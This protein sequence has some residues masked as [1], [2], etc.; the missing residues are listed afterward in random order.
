MDLC[1]D[2]LDSCLNNE[3]FIHHFVKV[4]ILHS[5][6][7]SRPINNK[8]F[9]CHMCNLFAFQIQFSASKIYTEQVDG[10][11]ARMSHK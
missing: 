1:L 4:S 11:F 9:I 2:T 5:L 8:V 10:V 3:L 6:Q 7:I